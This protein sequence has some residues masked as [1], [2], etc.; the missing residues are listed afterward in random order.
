MTQTHL[1]G[2]RHHGPGS[3]HAVVAE[4][5]RVRPELLLVEGPPE[6]DDLMRFAADEGMRP[7]VALL[8]YVVEEPRRA[9]FWPFASFSPEWQAIRWAVANDVP[10]RFCD[11][12]AAMQFATEKPEEDEPKD[13][14][15]KVRLDPLAVLAD[16]AGYDDAERWWEDVVEHRLDEPSP[17]PAIAEAM[18]AVRAEAPEL[19]E[20]RRVREQQR[21]AYMRKV[22]R[23]SVKQ[24]FD[25]IAVV[26]G[27]WHVPALAEMPT[28]AADNRVLKGLPRRKVAMSWVPWTHGRL[29]WWSG[30][31]AG[32][33]SPGWYHHLF[34]SAA[35]G[36][37]DIVGR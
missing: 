32:V 36:R 22:L 18:T 26:C 29:S 14:A 16:A 35:R 15:V 5:E 11:L 17:F 10:V 28:A 21:E 2:I 20:R 9:A 6:A 27:A 12:P 1:L 34:D 25:N 7:P 24:G 23:E 30:Y 33:A 8:G 19:P 4:L 37:A 3:A 13:D 31:G